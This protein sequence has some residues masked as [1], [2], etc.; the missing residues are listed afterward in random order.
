VAPADLAAKAAA[1]VAIKYEE[2]FYALYRRL[3]DHPASGARRPAPGR[4]I[5]I[6]VVSPY[7]VI[8]RY[9]R[10]ADTVTV[11]RIHHG[12]RRITRRLLPATH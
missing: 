10:S 8:Y 12:R 6:G 7:L 11:L 5:R 1:A 2:L 9:T 4:D 3:V